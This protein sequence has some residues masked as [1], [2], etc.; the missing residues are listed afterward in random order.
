[1]GYCKTISP[2]HH[3]FLCTFIID[4]TYCTGPPFLH[5]NISSSGAWDHAIDALPTG[6]EWW[7]Y[8]AIV[9][10]RERLS[11]GS[12]SSC[13]FSWV[14]LYWWRKTSPPRALSG[15]P[16]NRVEHAMQATG[17]TNLEMAC[18]KRYYEMA[19]ALLYLHIQSKLD[20]SFLIRIRTPP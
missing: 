15:Q 18:L 2:F 6:G 19:Q 14:A 12:A 10:R 1:L 9:A 16:P 7:Q 4:E 11:R 13:A 5:R 17:R 3:S 20:L 8:H